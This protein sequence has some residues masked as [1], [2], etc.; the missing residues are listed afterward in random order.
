MHTTSKPR[1]K[2][3]DPI[4]RELVSRHFWNPGNHNLR[5]ALDG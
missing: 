4:K 2:P 5:L 1:K 3:L